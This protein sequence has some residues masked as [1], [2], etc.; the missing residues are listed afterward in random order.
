LV[1]FVGETKHDDLVPEGQVTPKA[2]DFKGWTD[3]LANRLEGRERDQRLPAVAIDGNSV[4]GAGPRPY[5]LGA[6]A[7]E[8]G[9]VIAGHQIPDKSSEITELAT[10][11]ADLDLTGRAITMDA[12]HTQRTTAE[13]LAEPRQRP[14]DGPPGRLPGEGDDI[15]RQRLASSITASIGKRDERSNS[16]K[17]CCRRWRIEAV[18]MPNQASAPGCPPASPERWRN[19]LYG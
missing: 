5:L 15:D 1:S 16:E 6:A 4:R 9:I 3:L 11:I 10:L 14:G 13:H 8:G 12:L 17:R 18:R 19:P 7:H 2:S